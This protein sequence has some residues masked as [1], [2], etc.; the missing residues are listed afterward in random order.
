ME[1]S[2]GYAADV[3]K[4]NAANT[5]ALRQREAAAVQAGINNQLA[6]NN[7]LYINREDALDLEKLSVDKDLLRKKIRRNLAS[8][9]AQSVGRG[10]ISGSPKDAGGSFGAAAA[11]IERYGLQALLAKDVNREKRVLDFAQRTVNTGLQTQSA[12]NK[13]FSELS[14]GVAV[15]DRTG[16]MTGIGSDV[17][18][19][20]TIAN[21]GTT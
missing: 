12:N 20:L 16:L 19:G 8:F 1:R 2:Q 18:K 17:I 5:Q 14:A 3:N 4:A 15:P 13:L 11:N 6:V 21:S 9:A 7:Y 10:L